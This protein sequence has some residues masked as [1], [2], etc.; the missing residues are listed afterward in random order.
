MDRLLPGFTRK[1]DVLLLVAAGYTLALALVIALGYMA[2]SSMGQ[3]HAVTRDLYAHSFTV[4]N[5][6]L[7]ACSSALRLHN[8]MLRI[9]LSGNPGETRRLLAEAV[10]AGEL[11][12]ALGGPSVMMAKEC[13][14]RA[15]ETGLADGVSYE[16]RLFHSLFGT[17]DQIEG[18]DAFLAKRK[19][20]FQR[21]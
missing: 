13:V 16:R 5:A 9:A 14:N 17:P 8:Q 2:V 12:C 15:F 3:L 19:P 1:R 4:S 6:A 21:G 11:I 20:A 10:A 7:E 18:M